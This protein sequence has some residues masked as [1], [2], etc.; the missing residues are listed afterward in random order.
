M[1]FDCI[2]SGGVLIADGTFVINSY[3]G[4]SLLF[5]GTALDRIPFLLGILK[6]SSINDLPRLVYS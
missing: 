5:D 1:S 3:L 6:G 2:T 4:F